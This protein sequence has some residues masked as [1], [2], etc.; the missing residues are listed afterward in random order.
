MKLKSTP[1]LSSLIICGIAAGNSPAFCNQADVESAEASVKT[2]EARVGT[3]NPSYTG[4]LMY[5]AGI[6]QANGM[7]EKADTTFAKAIDSCKTRTDGYLQV[8]H[9]MLNWAMALASPLKGEQKA[10]DADLLKA[11]KIL[12]DGLALANALP[13][14]AK[15]RSSFL[16]G[17]VNFYRVI[18]NKAKE[19]ARLKA[20]DEYLLALE[21][22]PKLGN[23]EITQVAYDLVQMSNLYCQAPQPHI[24]KMLPPVNVVSDDS[25]NKPN[26]VK[27][28]D[29]KTAEAYQLRAIAQYDRLPETVPWRVEAHRSLI[30][31]YRHFGQAKQE[32]LQTQELCKLMHTTDR[33]LLFP[34]HR[35]CPGCGMG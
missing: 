22:N 34:Q 35:P 3:S 29:F 6:Y 24:M 33:S 26:T 4:Q 10:S 31:W 32:E 28:K 1:V 11:E 21:K 8:P 16:L 27:L 20:A 23:S 12:Q 15:E 14:S 17:S 5:L 25:P 19:Q 2:F 18:D 30:I 13:T 9:L 7:R